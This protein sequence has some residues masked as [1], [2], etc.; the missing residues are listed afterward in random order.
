VNS[1]NSKIQKDY[2]HLDHKYGYVPNFDKTQSYA[3]GLL[4]ADGWLTKPICRSRNLAIEVLESDFID[5]E[6]SL[7]SLGK[8]T[9]RKRHRN[10]RNPQAGALITNK[11]L[12]EWLFEIGFKDKSIISPNKLMS[13]IPE[14][15]KKH[16]IR[17]WVDG[18]GCF[19]VHEKNNTFQF[20]IA[21]SYEQD[22]S[23]FIEILN[24]LKIKYTY[25]QKTQIQNDR[26]NKCSIIRITGLKNLKVFI[27]YIYDD[28][29]FFLKRKYQKALIIK[30]RELKFIKNAQ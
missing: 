15:C 20:I 24:T 26:A 16:F 30:N 1:L 23:S 27:D 28:A 10:G 11:N 13:F 17:G 8:V 7:S 6:E 25:K 19:Y 18:D 22:W 29:D 21:G 12:C 4:W 14:K 9:V 5:F 3:L 2:S